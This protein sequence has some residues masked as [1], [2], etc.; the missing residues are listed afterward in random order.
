MAIITSAVLN[1]IR[2]GFRKN[3]EDGKTR[4]MPMFNAVATVVPSSTKSN[5]YG[6]LGQWPGFSEW[7]GDQTISGLKANLGLEGVL[8]NGTNHL[9]RNVWAIEQTCVIR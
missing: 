1:A 9:E 5:T 8:T 3:F 7:V 4:G 6:W 2:T